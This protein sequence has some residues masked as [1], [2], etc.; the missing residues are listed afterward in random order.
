MSKTRK[1]CTSHTHVVAEYIIALPP[2]DKQK[3]KY[4]CTDCFK[5]KDVTTVKNLDDVI[6]FVDE[7]RRNLKEISLKRYIKEIECSYKDQLNNL[8]NTITS[9]L[10]KDKL[11]K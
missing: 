1:M 3:W 4:G 7:L 10:Q 8:K 5:N 2:Q 9:A 6:P 11:V